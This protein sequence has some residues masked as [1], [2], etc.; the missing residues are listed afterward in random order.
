M[1]DHIHIVGCPKTRLTKERFE[2]VLE[3]GYKH[4][5]TGKWLFNL[6]NSRFDREHIYER[7]GYTIINKVDN[8]YNCFN[9]KRMFR[10]LIRNDVGCL[11]YFN[12]QV[13]EDIDL[14]RKYVRHGYAICLRANKRMRIVK[15]AADFER[16]YNNY[17][18]ATK[19]ED[20]LFEYRVVI[21]H[22]KLVN[23]FIKNK[24]DNGFKYK[25]ENCTF[26]RLTLPDNDPVLATSL[27]A[28]RVLGIDLC[29]VDILVNKNKEAK[30]IEVNSGNGMMSRTIKKILKILKSETK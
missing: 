29:G 12:F 2:N 25:Q 11:K 20:K 1:V 3:E 17:T 13:Q 26:A 23:I 8:V 5:P 16:H 4:V 27:K 6:G 22:N 30:I 21:L 28:A 10:I 18:Y 14:V 7:E 19:V 9:K 15:T 24:H